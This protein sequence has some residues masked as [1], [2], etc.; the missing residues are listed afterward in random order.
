MIAARGWYP[1]DVRLPVR[2]ALRLCLAEDVGMDPREEGAAAAG[3]SQ[4]CLRSPNVT[5]WMLP[6]PPPPRIWEVVMHALFGVSLV[7]GVCVFLTSGYDWV[8][9]SA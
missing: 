6:P 9:V 3:A 5:T 7:V 4:D 8:T 1:S 2:K